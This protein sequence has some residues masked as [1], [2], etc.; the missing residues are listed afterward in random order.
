[1]F[2]LKKYVAVLFALILVLGIAGCNNKNT[3][4]SSDITSSRVEHTVDVAYLA[5]KGQIPEL[6]VKLG[7]SVDMVEVL[8]SQE[9][10]VTE[11]TEDGFDD[12]DDVQL[13]IVKG[14]K[15][16]KIAAGAANYYYLKEN[17]ENGISVLVNFDKSYDFEVGI[18]MIDDIRNAVEGEGTLSVPT[19][20]EMFF[21]PV[22]PDNCQKLSYEIGAYRLDFYFVDDFLAATVLTDT[23]NWKLPTESGQEVEE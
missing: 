14:E 19:E 11:T 8:Y 20:E 10:S 22:A 2:N 18:A 15:T 3:E 1:M 21:F 4:T 16:V 9:S 7:N 13:E 5:G 23:V 12:H 17:E 6:P